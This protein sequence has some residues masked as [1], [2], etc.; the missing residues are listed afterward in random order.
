MYKTL[1]LALL[2]TANAAHALAA[3]DAT[4][5]QTADFRQWQKRADAEQAAADSALTDLRQRAVAGEAEAQFELGFLYN[6]GQGVPQDYGKAHAW[7]EKAAAQGF[8]EAQQNL[9]VLYA[10]GQG[11]RQ[12]YTKA[13]EWFEKAAAQDF[14]EAQNNLGILYNNGLGVAQDFVTARKW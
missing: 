7:Y 10:E 5:K 1:C 14:A 6:E 12:N 8:P 3:D 4:S 13:R 11:V 2:L 9:G